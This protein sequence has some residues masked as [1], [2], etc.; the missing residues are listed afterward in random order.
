MSW[1]MSVTHRTGYHYAAPVRASYNEARMTPLSS[2]RGQQTLV[3]RL[4]LS[5]AARPLRYV[6]YWGTVVHAFDVQVPHGELVVTAT[7]VVETS[8]EPAPDGDELSWRELSEP[9]L[10]DQFGELLVPSTYV[11]REPEL[12]AVAAELSAVP[13]VEAGRRAAA[14]AHEQ[15]DYERGM[16]EVGT[17]SAQARAIGKGVCQDYTHLALAL[18]RQTGLPGRY[19]S[20]YLHPTAD[21]DVGEPALGESHAWVE[22]WTGSWHAVDPTSLVDVG[23]RHIIVARGRDYGDVRP[24]A[25]VYSGPPATALGV[26]VE[27]TRLR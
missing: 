12:A 15:L 1:R 3:S 19:V 27:M 25:G 23:D 21:P 24:L 10:R 17:T 18:L 14:W 13:P 16:T 26:T 22:Y 8:A 4:D 2:P 11:V 7:S 20:G 6:D 9:R 5:P